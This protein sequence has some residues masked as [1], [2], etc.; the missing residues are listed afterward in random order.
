M[1]FMAPKDSVR[2]VN[3]EVSLSCAAEALEF[4]DANLRGE[5]NLIVNNTRV[6]SIH[7]CYKIKPNRVKICTKY[8]L[9]KLALY[10]R[11]HK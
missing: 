4:E 2:A 7:L 10:I 8:C 1:T 3:D 11:F 9:F 5:I 6:H